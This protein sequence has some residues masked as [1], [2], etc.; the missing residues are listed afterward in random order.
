MSEENE[1]LDRYELTIEDINFDGVTA[2]S[3]VEFPA[4]EEN[5]MVFSKNNKNNLTL[6]KTDNDKR[7]I[8]GPAMIPNKDIYRID[9]E[10]NQEYDIYFSEETV[11]NISE[12][13]LITN[14]LSNIN[15]EHEVNLN[16]VSLVESW[17]VNEPSNDKSNELGFDVNKGTWMIS[18]K[19]NNDNLWNNIIKEGKVNG[20]SIEGYFSNRFDK[21]STKSMTDDEILDEIMKLLK[22][23]D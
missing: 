4:I 5:F 21:H 2:I 17:I 3:I 9:F 1:K 7:I 16:D 22:N 14:K 11:K 20:F 6:S 15:L 12:Q 18:L 10:T 19:V 13:F 8:T 23:I